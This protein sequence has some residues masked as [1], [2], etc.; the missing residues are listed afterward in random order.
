MSEAE[1]LECT[2]VE[3]MLEFL[4]G[5]ASDRKL[6]LFAVACCRR[7]WAFVTS[8]TDRKAIETAETYVDGITDLAELA[9]IYDGDLN[10][11][12][13]Y[14]STDNDDAANGNAAGIDA[15]WT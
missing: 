3:P 1:W 12:P 5:M 15:A 9:A 8:A 14:P 10:S 11:N 7:V 4:K 6:R 2:D 13:V